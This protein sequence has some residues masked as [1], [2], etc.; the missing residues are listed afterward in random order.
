[1]YSYVLYVNDFG[2]I[3]DDLAL[4]GWRLGGFLR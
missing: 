3:F 2:E 1:M 4:S